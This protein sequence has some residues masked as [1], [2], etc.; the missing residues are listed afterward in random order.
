MINLVNGIASKLKS[1][2]VKINSDNINFML[3]NGVY[4]AGQ[5]PHTRA[6]HGKYHLCC[7]QVGISYVGNIAEKPSSA[8]GLKVVIG[9]SS[10]AR[11]GIPATASS[12]AAGV[13]SDCGGSVADASSVLER[14]S[15]LT[16][17]IDPPP[18]SLVNNCGK[19]T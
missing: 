4:F 18:T 14:A 15:S 13:T 1:F 7:T 11:D 5:R 17:T 16:V 3:K 8:A 19:I 2:I 10:G 9:A 6:T 12:F